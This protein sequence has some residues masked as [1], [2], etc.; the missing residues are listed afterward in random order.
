MSK[1]EVLPG[2]LSTGQDS[3]VF[4]WHNNSND[5]KWIFCWLS[6]LSTALWPRL[7]SLVLLSLLQGVP[8]NLSRLFLKEFRALAFVTCSGKKLYSWTTHGL[9]CCWRTWASPCADSS[10]ASGHGAVKHTGLNRPF[11]LIPGMNI[12]FCFHL[13]YRTLWQ[14]LKP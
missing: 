10:L 3:G 8:R 14:A 7:L 11:H 4:Y 5:H 9:P 2:Q 13:T 6:A 1:L 12:S